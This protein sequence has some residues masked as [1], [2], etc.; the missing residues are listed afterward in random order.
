M[1]DSSEEEATEFLVNWFAGHTIQECEDYRRF[2]VLFEQHTTLSAQTP[3]LNQFDNPKDPR[4]WM[5]KYT[6]LK[7]TT[8]ARFVVQ[9]ESYEKSKSALR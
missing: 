6:H 5:K 9:V 8:P 2:N 1:W 4:E 7:I 3:G